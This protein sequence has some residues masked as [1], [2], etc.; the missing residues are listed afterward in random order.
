MRVNV[1]AHTPEAKR[2]AFAAVRT[3]YSPNVPS[4]LFAAEFD[5][6]ESKRV[7]E[8]Q[9]TNEINFIPDSDR[10]LRQIASHGHTST[11]EH[12]VFTFSIEGITRACLAQ[13]TRHRIAS[14]SVQSQR[15]VKQST[16]SKHGC[17]DFD[18]PNFSY[19]NAPSEAT[20]IFED[21]MGQI[22]DAYD[23]LILLGV[24][25]EDARALL[26]NAATTN[27]VMT[28]NLR[29]LIH[30]YK[31]RNKE[32]HAQ[33]EIAELAEH[34]KNAVVLYEPWTEYFFNL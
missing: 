21:M 12:V 15:Y 14:Y 17:F 6:Y 20:E 10:L 4:E 7:V 25:A 5:E 22:Q 3:C 23:K 19:C 32:T 9:S 8:S 31:I 13:L 24:K 16:E 18:T 2:V 27:V 29:S 28:M 33:A 26:P 1:L 34:L 11:L 30:F